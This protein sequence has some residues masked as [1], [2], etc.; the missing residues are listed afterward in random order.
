MG[1]YRGPLAPLHPQ[2]FFCF[3]FGGG[4]PAAA[5]LVENVPVALDVPQIVYNKEDDEAISTNIGNFVATTWHSLGACPMKPREQGGVVD[6]DLNVY[7]VTGLKI[8]DLS[9]PY[10]NVNATLTP[11]LL[12]LAKKRR[13]L[14]RII[15][16][17]KA[18]KL[19]LPDPLENEK[20][21]IL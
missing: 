18:F 3:F 2:F 11:L 6:K 1:I 4:G 8:A 5:A 16:E 17:L 14:S 20:K 9:I 15:L 19:G 12:Q 10:A 7:G 21:I 13:S